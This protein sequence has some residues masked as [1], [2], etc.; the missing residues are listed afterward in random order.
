MAPHVVGLYCAYRYITVVRLALALEVIEA[1]F[2]AEEFVSAMPAIAKIDNSYRI[3]I[4]F[5]PTNNF[6]FYKYCEI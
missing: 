1:A 5:L 4:I 6:C 3:F 2:T